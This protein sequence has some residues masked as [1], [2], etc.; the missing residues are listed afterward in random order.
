[1]LK[2]VKG[3]PKG[4]KKIGCGIQLK[5][6]SILATSVVK[7]LQNSGNAF[8]SNSRKENLT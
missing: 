2:A 7:S 4:D 5:G 8:I 3:G 1:M 6:N